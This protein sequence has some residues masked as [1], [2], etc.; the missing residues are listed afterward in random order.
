MLA[1]DP[2]STRH[3][4]SPSPQR[5]SLPILHVM[6]Q[7]SV[8][9][10]DYLHVTHL[11]FTI[12]TSSSVFCLRKAIRT[13]QY[14]PAPLLGQQGRRWRHEAVSQRLSDAAANYCVPLLN[15]NLLAY[16]NLLD[17]VSN[18]RPRR[19]QMRLNMKQTIRLF[20]S[21]SD[22]PCLIRRGRLDTCLGRV[23]LP[24]PRLRIGMCMSHG[25]AKL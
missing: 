1:T 25:L 14:L 5:L 16:D 23:T 19:P 20:D 24:S 17:L 7:V 13:Q 18:C 8:P 6:P 22:C 2:Q 10:T 3:I 4:F 15:T 12:R 9:V 21:A 11:N